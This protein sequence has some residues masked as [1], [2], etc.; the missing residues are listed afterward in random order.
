MRMDFQCATKADRRLAEF[1][2]RHV[3]EPLAG[4]GAKMIRIARQRL[5]AIGNGTGKI[6]PHEAYGRPIVPAFGKVGL[7]LDDAA[8]QLF[9]VG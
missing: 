5:L 8:E 4:S 9:S 2:Q 1:V 7:E 3:T 6:A